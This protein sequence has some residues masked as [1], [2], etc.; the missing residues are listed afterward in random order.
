MHLIVVYDSKESIKYHKFLK[1][2]LFWKQNSVFVGE[3][4]NVAFREIQEKIKKMIS[5]DDSVLIFSN[6]ISEFT[7]NKYGIDKGFDDNFI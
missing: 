3:V 6:L 5:D 7:I 4:S 1:K 2:Y